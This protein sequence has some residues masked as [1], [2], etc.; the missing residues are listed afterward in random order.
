MSLS[1]KDYIGTRLTINNSRFI[2]RGVNSALIYVGTA[3]KLSNHDL[4]QLVNLCSEVK[5]LFDVN[6]LLPLYLKK[7]KEESDLRPD[8]VWS[9]VAN[10]LVCSKFDAEEI[11]PKKREEM[12]FQ[13]RLGIG[14]LAVAIDNFFNSGRSLVDSSFE[15]R[16][17]NSTELSRLGI[18][19]WPVRSIC[20]FTG[21]AKYWYETAIQVIRRV[22]DVEKNRIEK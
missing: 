10:E 20:P 11:Y 22:Q 13:A 9:E 8:E 17:P 3:E 18:D 6:L 12:K 21:F 4:R 5:E 2:L 19:N 1:E 15:S 16:H 7:R 14:S